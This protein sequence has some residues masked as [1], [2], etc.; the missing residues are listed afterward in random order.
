MI[1]VETIQIKNVIGN[2]FFMNP[3][4]KKISFREL[5]ML[6]KGI[7]RKFNSKKTLVNVQ[8]S[9]DDLVNLA[10]NYSKSLK[11]DFENEEV[12]YLGNKELPYLVTGVP[13]EIRRDFLEFLTELS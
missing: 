5:S 2:Y 12:E 3:C 6:K 10:N 4:E 7:E 1:Y 13:Q 9:R 8:Y 11:L